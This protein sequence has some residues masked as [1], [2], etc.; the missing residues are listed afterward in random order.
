MKSKIRIGKKRCCQIEEKPK[1]SK[2]KTDKEKIKQVKPKRKLWN[3]IDEKKEKCANDAECLD[4]CCSGGFML[5]LLLSCFCY[6]F[7]FER[8]M[9]FFHVIIKSFTVSKTIS[10]FTLYILYSVHI[11]LQVLMRHSVGFFRSNFHWTGWI[12]L[13][14]G[15]VFNLYADSNQ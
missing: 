3:Q 2:R 14:F 1:Q 13:F 8:L 7:D 9:S 15:L 4:E 11:Q 12:E 10:I 5:R 6:S